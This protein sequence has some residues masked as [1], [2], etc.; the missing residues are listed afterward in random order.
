[1]Y[2]LIYEPKVEKSIRKLK[3]K[4]PALAK[5]LW[6]KLVE[7][8]QNPEHFKPLRGSEFG[9]RQTHV[10]SFVVKFVLRGNLIK[11]LEFEHHA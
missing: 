1:M 8:H 4:D 6:K 11:I 10:G 2:D 9:K 3:K 7:I 5:Q